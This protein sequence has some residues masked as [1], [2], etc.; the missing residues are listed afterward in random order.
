MDYVLGPPPTRIPPQGISCLPADCEPNQGP[1]ANN[2]Q[3]NFLEQKNRA[4]I[5]GEYFHVGEEIT[6]NGPATS[7]G[8]EFTGNS[9][10][11]SSDLDGEIGMGKNSQGMA[12]LERLSYKGGHPYLSQ[13]THKEGS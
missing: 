12:S 9:L 4:P 6:F 2:P 1:P 13:L 7:S 11:C 8:N 3:R 10:V 5:D